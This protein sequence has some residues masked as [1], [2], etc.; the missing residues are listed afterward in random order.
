MTYTKHASIRTL[1]LA[2]LGAAAVVSLGPST[3][4][5]DDVVLRLNCFGVAMAQGRTGMI[6]IGIERWSNEAEA[7][8]LRTVLVE[9]KEGDLLKALKK[10][11]PRAGYMR[12]NMGGTG[13]D[14]DFARMFLEPDG[15]RKIVI[16][17]DRHIGFA[18][19]RNDGRSMDYEFTVVEIRLN[20]NGGMEGE[21][22]AAG[23]AK[24]TYN[25]QA[26][27]I[28]IE[29]YGAEP[30]LLPDVKVIEKK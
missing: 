5:G 17:T 12:F 28:E 25:K 2:A 4:A 22:K 15:S 8:T 16:A 3:A 13:W 24:V 30:L 1:A 23:A 27:R 6:D 9:K 10:L 26:K 11:R 19:A 21:G 29:K 7:Q 20:K 18:E 14:I